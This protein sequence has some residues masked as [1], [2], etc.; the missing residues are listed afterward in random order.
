MASAR[1]KHIVCRVV[2]KSAGP[3]ATAHSDF[4]H[5]ETSFCASGR[6]SLLFRI[7]QKWLQLS[8]EHLYCYTLPSLLLT[9][10]PRNSFYE[11]IGRKRVLKIGGTIFHEQR[12]H[13]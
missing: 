5:E 8:L 13:A 10:S 11:E 12:S 4:P 7:T 2:Q 1:R 9:F 3:T 6:K